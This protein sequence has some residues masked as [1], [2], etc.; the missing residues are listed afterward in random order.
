MIFIFIGIFLTTLMAVLG[1]LI[2]VYFFQD[3]CLNFN[4][5]WDMAFEL[6][7]IYGLIILMGG[8]NAYLYKK[9][10]KTQLIILDCLGNLIV[11]VAISYMYQWWLNL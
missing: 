5:W 8:I 1:R 3:Q 2:F 10:D 4:C 9:F 6:K 11:C 7:M